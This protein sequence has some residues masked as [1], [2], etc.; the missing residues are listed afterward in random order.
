MQLRL[1]DG[2]MDTI[3]PME[4]SALMSRIRSK[5]TKPEMT[6][7]KLLHSMGYRFRLHRKDLPGCPDIVLPR[8]KKAILVQG[9]FW[10]GHDCRL[11]SKPKSNSGYWSEKILKNKERDARNIAALQAAGWDV[12]ELWE[13]DVRRADCLEADL[14]K[15]LC[16]QYS[17]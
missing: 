3:S 10:H 12:L 14:R 16:K 2:I 17:S 9:C 6:V 7:R 8:H 4:R 13:C 1:L 11:A 15:F 5:D